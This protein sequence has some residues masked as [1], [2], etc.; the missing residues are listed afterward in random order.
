MEV[1]QFQHAFDQFL[2]FFDLERINEANRK[3]LAEVDDLRKDRTILTAYYFNG[4]A[5]RIKRERA[6]RLLGGFVNAKIT[7]LSDNETVIGIDSNTLIKCY[8]FFGDRITFTPNRINETK[9]REMTVIENDFYKLL[10]QIETTLTVRQEGNG[11]FVGIDPRIKEQDRIELLRKKID[12]IR[13]YLE[14]L[15]CNENDLNP[16]SRILNQKNMMQFLNYL[17]SYFKILRVT[18]EEYD[19]LDI[20]SYNSASYYDKC[21]KLYKIA[22]LIE[23]KLTQPQPSE[24]TPQLSQ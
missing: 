2:Q 7:S 11:R 24:T 21:S 17:L 15:P 9:Q 22:R 6:F 3:L 10:S 13:A 14:D 4:H 8:T 12:H 16:N 5:H 23:S 1:K 18:R 20:G 19:D